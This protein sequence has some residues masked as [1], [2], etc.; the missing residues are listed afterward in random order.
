MRE[1]LKLAHFTNGNDPALVFG[2][3][4]SYAM[5]I[6]LAIVCGGHWCHEGQYK[7]QHNEEGRCEGHGRCIY[8]D[9][10]EYVGAWRADRWEG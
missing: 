4:N 8:P 6:G 5:E 9:G 10:S 1:Q 7:G 2:L 3:Y